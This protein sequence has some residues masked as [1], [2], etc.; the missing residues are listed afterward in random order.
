MTGTDGTPRTDQTLEGTTPRTNDVTP[1]PVTNDTHIDATN[2][3]DVPVATEVAETTP[4]RSRRLFIGL[5]I[6][7]VTAAVVAGIAVGARSVFAAGR[8]GKHGDAGGGVPGQAQE[9]G[10]AH[11]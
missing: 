1:T 3:Y 8:R 11:V 9:I 6:A 5:G 4:R 7:G 10:R 2:D